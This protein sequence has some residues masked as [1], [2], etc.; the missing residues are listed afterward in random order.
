[1]PLNLNVIPVNWQVPGV[2]VGIDGSGAVQGTSTQRQ[3][4]LIL[5][6]RRTTGTILEKVITPI[7]GPNQGD[8]YFGRGSQLAAMCRA[9]NQA[10][11][12]VEAYAMA[13]DEDAAGVKATATVTVVGTATAAGTLVFLWGGRLRKVAVALGDTPTVIAASIAAADTADLDSPTTST[14][15]LGVVT[16]TARHK[17]AYGNSLS[18][19]LNYFVGDATPAGISSVTI[20]DFTGGT[21]DPDV[22]GAVAALGGDTPYTTIV[23]PWTADANMDILETEMASR[24]S[25]LRA[26]SGHIIA[27]FR[28]TYAASQTYGNARNSQFS[29]VLATA[30]SPTP[31]WIWASS[32][33][34][35]ELA[36]TDPA[37][38][39]Q[40]VKIP[41]VYAPLE[42]N[43]FTIAERNLLLMDGMATY[44]V[45][46]G[47]SYI[48]RLVT[49]Y[50]TNAQGD[51]DPSYHDIEVMRCLAFFR[52]G[53]SSR[54]K[55]KYPQAKLGNDGEAFSPGQIVM[56]PRLMRGECLAYF[57]ELN[58]LAIVENRKQF[59]A[60]LIVERDQNNPNQ[61]NVL[62][63]PDFV[64]QFRITAALIAFKL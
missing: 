33:A 56:T 31:P 44:T 45:V 52:Y 13:L 51:E 42:A 40:N 23:M 22:T 21:T 10:N 48:E 57:D 49:T 30:K 60:Q 27:A 9:F 61:M 15:A 3:I 2:Y 64:N 6:L 28:G 46:S 20:T 41:G 47:D 39:R 7:T 53:F 62:L 50:Q 17:G 59:A 24:W 32:L 12:Y 43:R 38:P 25:P 63:P 18:I 29:S 11:P 34:A 37:R 19:F 5:G 26:L 36:E 8:T 4:A 1:M 55:R 54:I 35:I 14:S 16:A 58:L